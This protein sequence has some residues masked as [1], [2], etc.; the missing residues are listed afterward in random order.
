MS[1]GAVSG[2]SALEDLFQRKFA[3]MKLVIRLV[4]RDLGAGTQCG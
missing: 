1:F 2:A 4:G 3:S